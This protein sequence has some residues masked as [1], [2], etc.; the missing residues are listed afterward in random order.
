V[1]NEAP[2]MSSFQ[3]KKFYAVAHGYVPGIYTDWATANAQISGY[4][5][6]RY[7]GFSTRLEADQWLATQQST[8][9]T[10]PSVDVPVKVEAGSENVS[11]TSEAVNGKAAD[12]PA[13]KQKKNSAAIPVMTN[14]DLE[15]GMG[16]LPPGSV[17]GF[18]RTIK[19]DPEGGEIVPRTK[20]EMN[21]QVWQPTGEFEGPLHIWTD[22]SSLGNGQKGAAAGVGVYFGPNDPK[23][24][25][26]P[27]SFP[28]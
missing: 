4:H 17:D 3:V 11:S 26:L 6:S 1:K 24:A 20:E 28:I 25:P 10:Q 21:A 14:G 8:A 2:T 19:L 18:D 9:A 16:P 5:G 12:G 13:K 23:Y 15:P 27:T 22:G 7:E